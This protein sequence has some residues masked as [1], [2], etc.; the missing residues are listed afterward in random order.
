MTEAAGTHVTPSISGFLGLTSPEKKSIS[1][2]LSAQPPPAEA[3]NE[4]P[5]HHTSKFHTNHRY[6]SSINT[7]SQ[8]SVTRRYTFTFLLYELTEHDCEIG[9]KAL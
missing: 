3:S 4:S 5:G 8:N 2:N 6:Q 7:P 1:S 9:P